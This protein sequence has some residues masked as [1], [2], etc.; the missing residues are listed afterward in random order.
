MKINS[1][2]RLTARV[3]RRVLAGSELVKEGQF[4]ITTGGNSFR[5]GDPG[6]AYTKAA[7]FIKNLE[8]D[9]W[10]FDPRG[11]MADKMD[12]FKKGG[13]EI[14]VSVRNKIL[15]IDLW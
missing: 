7:E 13:S 8:Y 4:N 6:Q 9:G 1:L 14:N 11:T 3:K 12:V 2:K 10:R 15:N 5:F